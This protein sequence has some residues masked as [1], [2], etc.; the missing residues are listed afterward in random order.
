MVFDHFHWKKSFPF[1]LQIPV[2]HCG[3]QSA[4]LGCPP[5]PSSAPR[6]FSSHVVHPTFTTL[7]PTVAVAVAVADHVSHVRQ[8]QR[9]RIKAATGLCA[10]KF[11]RPRTKRFAQ[12]LGVAGTIAIDKQRIKSHQERV[13]FYGRH[14][15]HVAGRH[16]QDR[17]QTCSR[18]NLGPRSQRYEIKSG[19]R[20]GRL[21]RT[22]FYP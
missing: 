19:G 1:P 22:D 14:H 5:Y 9:T 7:R 3:C 4:C 11:N 15:G 17:H 16:C 8:W 18:F 2:R 21:E 20:S 12:R 13:E 6:R 10:L